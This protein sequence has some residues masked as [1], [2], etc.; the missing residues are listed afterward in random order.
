VGAELGAVLGKVVGESLETCVGKSEKALLGAE[1]GM[2]LGS[3]GG[4]LD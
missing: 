3:S 4:T 1:L 2:V